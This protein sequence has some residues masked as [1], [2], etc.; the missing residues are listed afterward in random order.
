MN[1]APPKLLGTA[2][3]VIFLSLL[4]VVIGISLV[5]LG[6]GLLSPESLLW[7]GLLL[8]ALPIVLLVL[9]RLY[10]LVTARYRLDRD[11][12]FIAWGLAY[13]Q[14]PIGSI[15]RIRTGRELAGI[16]RPDLGFWWP[17]CLI[18]HTKSG[19]LGRVEFFAGSGSLVLVEMDS[20]G[21]IA[22]TPPDPE[23]FIAGFENARRM[24]A[25]ERIQVQSYRPERLL[26]EMRS[27]RLA[28]VLIAL[29]LVIPLALLAG[30]VIGAPNL[31]EQVPFGFALDQQPGPLVPRGRLVLLPVIAGL[32]WLADLLLGGW[33]YRIA[34][35]RPIA[36]ALWGTAV[37]SGVLLV[38]AT[39]LL[40]Q[41]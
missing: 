39:L 28:V 35:D 41:Q 10:G 25:L 8:L 5:N 17:G 22:L 6:Q 32:I 29:G 24:G 34:R 7:I 9:N 36:H 13:K 14:V 15:R 3:G 30:L 2:I 26:L 4:V 40:I 19:E 16:A 1:L 31:P 20:G 27:D 18:G 11:G 37:V 38:G 21:M 12:L 33:F 23:A